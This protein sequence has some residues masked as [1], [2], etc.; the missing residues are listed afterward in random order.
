MLRGS[1]TVGGGPSTQGTDQHNAQFYPLQWNLQVTQADDAWVPTPAGQG[2]LVCVLDTGVDPNHIDLQGRI[3]LSIS[4]STVTSPLF[5]GDTTILDFHFHGTHVSGIVSSNGI[6]IASVAP[7]ARLC[8]VK[9]LNVQGFGSWA[10]IIE[11]ISYAT[12]VGAN[13]INMSLRG[14]V[15]LRVPGARQLIAAMQRA[16]D[17][18]A[19]RGVLVVGAAGNEAVDLD[20][21]PW[22]QIVIPAQLPKVLSVGATAP[23]NQQNFDQL[24]SYS[25]YGGDTGIDMVAPGGDFVAGIALD[26]VLSACSQ[27][28]VYIECP[29]GTFYV[30]ASG[31]SMAAPHVSGAAAV[32]ESTQGPLGPGAMTQCLTR[33]ADPV[34]PFAIYGH[35]RLNVLQAAQC[36]IP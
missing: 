27:Y 26:G 23:V 9:V 22:Y 15:D 2:E 24:A 33:T 5:P 18:A 10:D 6:A 25:N 12:S 20:H 14:Y 3:D 31:T 19:S 34:G 21:D 28:S 36:A 8:A 7:D 13:V 35:G 1:P 30:F 4:R 17:K 16:I 29:G 32:L 11:G